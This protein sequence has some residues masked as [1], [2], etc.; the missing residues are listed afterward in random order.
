[1]NS[2]TKEKLKLI[3]YLHDFATTQLNNNILPFWRKKTID[4]EHNGFYGQINNDLTID[5]QA[6]KG[7]VLNARILWTF[8]AVY[9]N[10]KHAEDLELA[11]RAYEYICMNFFD[12]KYGGYYWSLKPDR[13][14]ADTKKQIYAQAFVIY[15]LSEYYK[16]IK[17]QAVLQKAID[18]FHLIEKHSFDNNKNGYVEA[19]SCEWDEMADIRL[20]AKD[21]NEKKSMN[22]HLHILEAYGNLYQVWKDPFLKKQLENLICIFSDII[23]DPDDH[24]QVLFFDDNWN[25]RSSTISYGHDIETSWLLH[26]AAMILGNKELIKKI[27]EQSIDMSRAV[28]EG[29]SPKGALYYESDREGRHSEKEIEWWAQAEAV[30]GFLNAYALTA[31]D[32]FL[33][34][35][36]QVTRFID[37]YVVDRKNGEWFFRVRESGEPILTHVKAGFWKCPYHNSRACLEILHR[38]TN[39]KR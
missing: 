26:E 19:R 10:L 35:A 31:D 38:I 2:M 13:S 11:Q 29:I 12:K 39:L 25:P 32:S 23:I 33:D 22:T 15:G 9:R 6:D 4:N 7:L 36:V 3:H 18:L 5:K 34:R 20:S 17:D 16:V 14:P 28:V 21:M 8:S 27:T 1:M 24:H 37:Q 30:V